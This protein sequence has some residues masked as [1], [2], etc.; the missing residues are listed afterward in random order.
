[1]PN[2]KIQKEIKENFNGKYSPYDFTY[3]ATGAYV[4]GTYL[5]QY[6]DPKGFSQMADHAFEVRKLSKGL[7]GEKVVGLVNSGMNNGQEKIDIPAD[8]SE[9]IYLNLKNVRK[10]SEKYISNLSGAGKK[11]VPYLNSALKILEFEKGNYFEAKTDNLLLFVY[12]SQLAGGPKFITKKVNGKDTGEPDF[13]QMEKNLGELMEPMMQF[14]QNYNDLLDLEY[15]KQRNNKLGWTPLTYGSYVNKLKKTYKAVI[16]NFEEMAEIERKN[17]GKYGTDILENELKQLV[18][19]GDSTREMTFCVENMKTQLK[20][21]DNGWDINELY[22]P[23]AV[24]GLKGILEKRQ[25]L[26]ENDASSYPEALESYNERL[27]KNEE[28]LKTLREESAQNRKKPEFLKIK[29]RF[30]E[31]N[32]KYEEH[33][34]RVRSGVKITP[35]EKDRIDKEILTPY[36]EMNEQVQTIDPA[37]FRIQEIERDSEAIRNEQ[38]PQAQRRIENEQPTR[39]FIN[40]TIEKI[41]E[42]N[43]ACSKKDITDEEKLDIVRKIKEINNSCKQNLDG[44]DSFDAYFLSSVEQVEKSIK[45]KQKLA[46]KEYGFNCDEYM[47]AIRNRLNDKKIDNEYK[48]I[49]KDLETLNNDLKRYERDFEKNG[50]YP[51]PELARREKEMIDRITAYN[52]GKGK[53]TVQKAGLENACASLIVRNLQD[54]ELPD[55][56]DFSQMKKAGPAPEEEKEDII[57][58]DNIIEDNI[59]IENNDKDKEND[60]ESS[61][62]DDSEED[63]VSFILE[64]E[65][66]KINLTGNK[67]PAEKTQGEKE[68]VV[69]EDNKEENHEEIVLDAEPPKPLGQDYDKLVDELKK[70]IRN[71]AALRK[72]MVLNLNDTLDVLKRQPTNNNMRTLYK[73]RR[74]EFND[75]A[76]KSLY[77]QILLDKYGD[78]S[79]DALQKENDTEKFKEALENGFKDNEDIRRN[80]LLTKFGTTFKDALL[81]KSLMNPMDPIP[82]FSHEAVLK[83]RDE[84]LFATKKSG[85]DADKKIADKLAN[86]FG[87]NAL[88]KNGEKPVPED[89]ALFEFRTG[90]ESK[91]IYEELDMDHTR[92]SVNMTLNLGFKQD[93]SRNEIRK[94]LGGLYDPLMEY[95][96]SIRE[97]KELEDGISEKKNR[98]LAS[99]DEANYRVRY[100]AAV[101]KIITKYE[102]LKSEHR[103]QYEIDPKA[104]EHLDVLTGSLSGITGVNPKNQA[105]KNVTLAMANMKARATA[106]ANGW[107]PEE[108]G[109]IGF[110]GETKANLEDLSEKNANNVEFLLFK[111]KFDRLY[112]ANIDKKVTNRYEKAEIARDI[113]EFVKSNPTD[114]YQKKLGSHLF[115]YEEA[116][117]KALD[118]Y[119][120]QGRSV[121][122]NTDKLLRELIAVDPAY[123]RSSPEFRRLRESVEKLDKMAKKLP[124]NPS[125]EQLDDFYSQAE[126]TYMR[127]TIYINAKKKEE[128]DYLAKNGRRKARKESTD[129]RMNFAAGLKD[130]LE[131]LMIANSGN[132]GLEFKGNAY[133]R[134]FSKMMRL[135]RKEEAYRLE[136]IDSLQ[137]EDHKAVYRSFC[138]SAYIESVTEKFKSD[139]EFTLE[140]FNKAITKSEIKKGADEMMD[141]FKALGL[142]NHLMKV[143]EC[144]VDV[145]GDAE[146]PDADNYTSMLGKARD[147]G[148]ISDEENAEEYFLRD[149]VGLGLSWVRFELKNAAYTVN[150]RYN[151]GRIKT[152]E[153]AE[154]AL[155]AFG[156]HLDGHGSIEKNE[157]YKDAGD[158]YIVGEI[159]KNQKK[160]EMVNLD[161]NHMDEKSLRL[162]KETLKNKIEMPFDNTGKLSLEELNE[163]DRI[164]GA[165]LDTAAG[166][167]NRRIAR[168]GEIEKAEIRSGYKT[169]DYDDELAKEIEKANENFKNEKKL[170]E[171]EIEKIDARLKQFENKKQAE[172]RL[173]GLKPGTIF[174][175]DGNYIELLGYEKDKMYVQFHGDNKEMSGNSV[176]K[177]PEQFKDGVINVEDMAKL[178][179]EFKTKTIVVERNSG[180]IT[181]KDNVTVLENA[182]DIRNGIIKENRKDELSQS[183]RTFELT[184]EDAKRMFI[185]D[186]DKYDRAFLEKLKKDHPEIKDAEKKYS[187]TKSSVNYG[188]NIQGI[189]IKQ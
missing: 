96:S 93:K 134:A 153:E 12:N 94:Q 66:G 77:Y 105:G 38:I 7:E 155:S 122:Q 130:K 159:Y 24:G 42:L 2:P 164:M 33:V 65:E 124:E 128:N 116:A 71:E 90:L 148:S 176:K 98:G 17:P 32:R 100:S 49:V 25:K 115:G 103:T 11:F 138:K 62:D 21:I 126:K 67:K 167:V 160:P 8:L 31:L 6:A 81:R 53:N 58:N 179:Y 157:Q 168:R 131:A 13:E 78:G 184:K 120:M 156:Y 48:D 180:K 107:A 43:E 162:R 29:D 142:K 10:N 70:N 163:S 26:F 154:E 175:V 136:K 89:N 52:E 19:T 88:N 102:A 9:K 1:M 27:A 183:A 92:A 55:I 188:D 79:R 87:S 104:S 40:E 99:L 139:P 101:N 5:F 181:F 35:E 118:P 123:M 39:K 109:L 3:M 172:D 44:F 64:N 14:Y 186:L 143:I 145:V 68:P 127:A 84:A 73:K 4:A 121:H 125:N 69:H 45:F 165:G 171:E 20:A 178:D 135:Q 129:K 111:E 141:T 82:D 37:Y 119:K 61:L 74:D 166:R 59:I 151:R 169:F 161:I 75:S 174:I 147:D 46:N 114:F 72:N 23:A 22:V 187:K 16:D 85:N 56:H 173:R 34:E 54:K 91:N 112:S 28:N 97:L 36:R 177:V 132:R 57:L 144:K 133:E 158:D 18:T 185:Y 83:I 86:E 50:I 30:E 95:H 117:N 113:K 149:S 47:G 63:E 15:E 110:L 106:V 60:N 137:K 51:A 146:V 140:D 152:E 76:M 108:A 189:Q 182:T 150:G 41:D 80:V 170:A